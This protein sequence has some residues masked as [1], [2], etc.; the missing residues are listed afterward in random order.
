MKQHL[1]HGLIAAGLVIT[2]ATAVGVA[3]TGTSTRSQAADQLPVATG[4]LGEIVITGHRPNTS[5]VRED[6]AEQ[7]L[8]EIVVT[9]TPLPRSIDANTDLAAVLVRTREVAGAA[10][11][12]C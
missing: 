12:V 3:A 7:R 6:R 1:R 5:L 8:L 10:P 4:D 9:A 11:A 2:F